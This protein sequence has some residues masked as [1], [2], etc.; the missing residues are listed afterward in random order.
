MDSGTGRCAHMS[1][2]QADRRC[3]RRMQFR[4]KPVLEA[5][6]AS[7][8]HAVAEQRENEGVVSLA[9]VRRARRDTTIGLPLSGAWPLGPAMAIACRGHC[10]VRPKALMQG[11][12]LSPLLR[13]CAS[14]YAL[15]LVSLAFPL[16]GSI[17]L[18]WAMSILVLPARPE[19]LAA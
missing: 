6:L 12:P 16:H 10:F 14:G 9:A 18:C 8:S 4:G 17:T 11:H 13:G 5:G 7:L 19:S 3:R 15:S 1:S 2:W